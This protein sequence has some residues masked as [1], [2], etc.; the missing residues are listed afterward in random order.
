MLFDEV[1][2]LLE[3]C[4]DRNP[5][6]DPEPWE[7]SISFPVPLVKLGLARV[8]SLS[9]ILP[10]DNSV[11]LSLSRFTIGDVAFLLFLTSVHL[12]I[13]PVLAIYFS[14]FMFWKRTDNL[15]WQRSCLFFTFL[16]SERAF[17][18]SFL[19]LSSG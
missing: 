8:S 13:I 2:L 7:M 6:A 5:E 16:L 11:L 12:F 1:E 3:P 9:A 15:I 18:F 19:L 10:S 17:E 4:A 14:F